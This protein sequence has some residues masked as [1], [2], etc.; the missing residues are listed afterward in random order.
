MSV[1]LV[2]PLHRTAHDYQFILTAIDRFTRYATDVHLK[3][4][5]AINVARAFYDD[6]ICRY[7]VPKQLLSDR[8]AQFTSGICALLCRTFGI[9]NL[10]TTHYHPQ[11]N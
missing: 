3:S 7:G 9:N 2:G 11:C 6:V 1:D 5:S 10:F 4:V 8:G